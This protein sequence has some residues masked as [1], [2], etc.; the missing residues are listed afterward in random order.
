MAPGAREKK[1]EDEEHQRK[2][3]LD[4]DELFSDED[5]DTLRDPETGMRPTPPV[6][7]G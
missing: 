7:G 1:E 4:D 3:V 2:Y 5:R 6:I